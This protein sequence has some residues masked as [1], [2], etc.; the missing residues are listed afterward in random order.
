MSSQATVDVFPELTNHV[1]LANSADCPL[2]TWKLGMLV[3][4]GLPLG[5]AAWALRN[6]AGLTVLR[7]W[8][9]AETG[10]AA[11]QIP[12]FDPDLVLEIR[13]GTAHWSLEIPPRP[14]P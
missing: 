5:S 9:T 11:I 1:P 12:F 7:G 8:I 10:R 2:A 3:L 4:V 14:L 13:S 6:H